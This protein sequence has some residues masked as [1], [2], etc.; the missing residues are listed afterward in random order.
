M[1]NTKRLA[2]G[3]AVPALTGVAV[4]V[5]TAVAV[6]ALMI[7]GGA[8]AE[9]EATLA[10]SPEFVRLDVNHDG[11]ISREEAKK[12]PGFDRAFDQADSDHDGK[13]DA[14]EYIKARSI[15][16]RMQARAYLDDSVITGKVK[17]ALLKEPLISSFDVHVDTY[18]GTVQLSGFVDSEKQA[19]K[20][21]ETAAGI[22]GVVAVINNLTV[23]M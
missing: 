12:L 14:D 13:L 7:A 6:S 9:S 5:I 2:T 8:R 10:P 19:R 23:K 20:A 16:D 18:K 22:P 1:T 21:A 11:F 15:Y 3:V 17:A 4:S